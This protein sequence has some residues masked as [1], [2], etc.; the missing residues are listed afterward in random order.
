MSHVDVSNYAAKMVVGLDKRRDC[1]QMVGAEGPIVSID[2]CGILTIKREIV[3][4]SYVSIV[5]HWIE[6]EKIHRLK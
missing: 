1:L 5:L 3:R 4:S 2:Y 6:H